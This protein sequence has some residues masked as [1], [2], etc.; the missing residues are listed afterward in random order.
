MFHRCSKRWGWQSSSTTRGTTGCDRSS[1]LA[2]A[3]ASPVA[4]PRP[5]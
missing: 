3:S 1:G 2:R 5:H 4:P